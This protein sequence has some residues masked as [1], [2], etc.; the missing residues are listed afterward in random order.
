MRPY[1]ASRSIPNLLIGFTVAFQSGA[2]LRSAFD[3]A[4]DL[5]DQGASWG[6]TA[7]IMQVKPDPLVAQLEEIIV[8]TGAVAETGAGGRARFTLEAAR[9]VVD[10]ERGEPGTT[11][12]TTGGTTSGTTTGGTTGTT[13]G[14]SGG[15]TGTTGG[16]TSGSGSGGGSISGGSTTGS[17]SPTCSSIVECAVHEATKSPSP[18]PSES[19]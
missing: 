5:F 1:I 15:T 9:D 16:G 17:P 14:G 2:P 6:V 12:G 13:G 10:G 8:N 19:P 3:D 7:T 4:F 18:S 11:G